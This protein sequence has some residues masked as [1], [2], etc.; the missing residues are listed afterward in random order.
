MKK[1][2]F[3]STLTSS[4]STIITWKLS[5]AQVARFKTKLVNIFLNFAAAKAITNDTLNS[6]VSPGLHKM[7]GL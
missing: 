1:P 2:T 5:S 3:T 6:F 7:I 4:N